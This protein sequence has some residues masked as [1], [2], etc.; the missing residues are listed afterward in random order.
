[1][2]STSSTRVSAPTTRS[3]RAVPPLASTLSTMLITTRTVTAATSLV[4][5]AARPSVSPSLP[6][7]SPSRSLTALVPAPTPVFSTACNS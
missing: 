7:L 3:S 6:M 5:F 4:P 2:P 1:S